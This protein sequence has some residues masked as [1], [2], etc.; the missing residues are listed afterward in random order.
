MLDLLLI[1]DMYYFNK[2]PYGINHGVELHEDVIEYAYSKLHEFKRT[3]PALDCYEF[4]DP[5][6]VKGW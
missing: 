4:C 5:I 6:F 3:S 2:G 1:Y